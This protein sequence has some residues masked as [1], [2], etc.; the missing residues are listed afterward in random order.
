MPSPN[1]VAATFGFSA[2]ALT[3]AYPWVPNE[4]VTA[5]IAGMIGV[6]ACVAVI[7]GPRLNRAVDRKAWRLLAAAS[8]AFVAGLVIHPWSSTMPGALPL[9]GEGWTVLGYLLLMAAFLHWLRVSKALDRSAAI[10]GMIVAMGTLA[11]VVQYLAMPA[12]VTNHARSPVLSWVVAIYPVF[13]VVIVFLLANLMFSTAIASL[14]F[15]L[16]VA[17]MVCMLG[18]DLSYALLA[19]RGFIQGSQQMDVPYMLGFTLFGTAALHPSMRRMSTVVAQPVQA[20]S[21]PRLAL[22]LPALT[23]P[24]IVLAD[25]ARTDSARLSVVLL[26]GAVVIAVLA[27]AVTAVDRLAKSQ[28]RL[29][30]QAR[31]DALTGLINRDG[32]LELVNQRIQERSGEH[33]CVLYLDLDGFKL[34]N[35]HWGHEVGDALLISAARRL[36]GVV[37]PSAVVARTGGDEFAITGSRGSESDQLLVAEK[38]IEAFRRPFQ[39]ADA[40]LVVTASAGLVAATDQHSADMLLRDADVAMYRA[41]GDGRDRFSVFEPAMREQVRRR[42]ETELALRRAL[43]EDQLWVAYQP[44]TSMATGATLGAEALVRWD[45]PKG[46]SGSPGDFIAIAEESGLIHQ[47]GGLVLA[48]SI[49]QL[50][51]WRDA[52][53]VDDGFVMQVN[54]SVNQLTDGSLCETVLGLLRERDI[55][56]GSLTLEITESGL[57]SDPEHGEAILTS[58]REA[59]IGLAVDDFG[60]GYSSL[61]YLSTLPITDLKIDRSFVLKLDSGHGEAIIGAVVALAHSL[62]LKVTAEG[63]ETQTQL[64]TLLRL[65]VDKGQ[66]W[67]WGKAT[68]ASDFVLDHLAQPVGAAGT[69]KA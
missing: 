29:A 47:I 25:V 43:L 68:Q 23:A 56:P 58:L 45:A 22:I 51:D 1:K 36:Q 44:L 67:F 4:T 11:P 27:R 2:L 65:G 59:G 53:V 62:S 69:S 33:V 12:L 32:L 40:E 39:V 50:G 31:H 60:T 66:G 17:A 64:D 38:V 24:F 63:V 57:M 46:V 52:G 5:A 55:P 35:D 28:T 41:K 42:M 49:R 26:A 34:I 30:Y 37:G 7:V 20:W 19:A 14:A 61:N 13:D 6:G 10:D 3:A 48:K 18:G 9:L 21:L 15:R 8:L 16:I 54:L